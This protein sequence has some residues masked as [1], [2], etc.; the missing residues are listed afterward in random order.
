ML[1]PLFFRWHFVTALT[2]SISV[3]TWVDDPATDARERVHEALVRVLVC[4][5]L[6]SA[7]IQPE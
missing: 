2:A 1:P 6:N 7:L 3:N 4:Q 5:V